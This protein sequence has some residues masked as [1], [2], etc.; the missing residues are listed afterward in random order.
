M[1][2]G[3]GGRAGIGQRTDVPRRH[4]LSY[5]NTNYV[6]LGQVIETVTGHGWA[7]RVRRRILD[8]LGLRDTYVAGFVPA[9]WPPI[10]GYFDLDNDGDF[11]DVETDEP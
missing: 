10:A 8:P 1:V 9:H 6:L 2:S 3:R 5:S 4:R 11:D 7:Q